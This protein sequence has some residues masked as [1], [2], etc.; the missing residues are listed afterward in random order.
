MRQILIGTGKFIKGIGFNVLMTLI[1]GILGVILPNIPQENLTAFF[2]FDSASEL[3]IYIGIVIGIILSAVIILQL[4]GF[5]LV[6]W[7]RNIG[8]NIE[9]VEYIQRDSNSPYVSLEIVNHEKFDLVEC[10]GTLMEVENYYTLK[11]KIN[12]L[13]EV[14]PNRKLLSWGGG[15]PTESI[16]IP[17]NHGRKILNIA[18]LTSN[19]GFVF[20]FH[21]W[22]SGQKS[23]GKY[24]VV[25]EINGKIDE[26]PIK[27]IKYIGCFKS[28][29]YITPLT[30]VTSGRVGKDGEF[31][32]ERNVIYGG[33]PATKLDFIKCE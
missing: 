27:P 25:V 31:I 26:V 33:R 2:N 24:R 30:P 19:G 29:N 9:V 5:L 12:I 13:D 14:N 4:V 22:Q 1:I 7:G 3:F 21:G 16:T 11:T 15:S 17:R 6:S 23:V 32:A 18:T 10:Y 8:S 28:E 20:L